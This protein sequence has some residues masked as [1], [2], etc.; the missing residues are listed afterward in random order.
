[1][2]ITKNFCLL[3]AFTLGGMVPASAQEIVDSIIVEQK[4]KP[5]RE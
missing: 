3:A 2:G 1:M 4:T 5:M